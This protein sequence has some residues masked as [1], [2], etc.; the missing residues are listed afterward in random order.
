QTDRSFA[1]WKEQ[2]DFTSRLRFSTSGVNLSDNAWF[3]DFGAATYQSLTALSRSGRLDYRGDEW[4]LSAL[5]RNYQI[6]DPQVLRADRPYTVLPEIALQGLF[7]DRVLG[8]TFA[9]DGEL[10][11][12]ER[13]P[14]LPNTNVQRFVLTPQVRLPLRASGIY[15]EPAAGVRYIAFHGDTG[16]TGTP[17]VNAPIF[18]I[19]SG[20]VFERTTEPTGQRIQTLEPRVLYAYVP[21][22]NQD[23]LPSGLIDTTVPDFNLIQLFE[24]DRYTGGDRIGDVNHVA[25]GLTSRLIDTHDGRQFLS[26]TI[27]E[28]YRFA[29]QRVALTSLQEVPEDRGSSDM[30]GELDLTAYKNWSAHVALQ[31]D[32]SSQS[33]QR[34]EVG[35]QFRPDNGKVINFSYRYRR[36]SALATSTSSIANSQQGLEQI[37]TS[38]AWP[39]GS[40]W[41][42]YGR[43]IYSLKDAAAIERFAGF[44]YRSCCWGVRV[45]VRRYV[46]TL[47]GE[48]N[49]NNQLQLELNGLSKVGHPVDTFLAESIRGYS[50]AR[51]DYRSTP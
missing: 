10:A 36:N 18:S 22:R 9:I 37:D 8:L 27:G 49:W 50:A 40:A 16:T 26:A 14:D 44:E 51:N 24:V 15:I 35:F 34:T 31:W 20:M 13:S 28:L 46:S 29:P 19:D 17:S 39:I 33:N 23:G 38:I 48:F 1:E 3:E 2:T 7:P 11:A 6:I 4:S 47:T 45:L 32:P 30:I 25:L 5:A 41:S 21:Y 12:F 43:M 42:V